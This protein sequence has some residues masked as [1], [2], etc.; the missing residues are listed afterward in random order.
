MGGAPTAW[1][2]EGRIRK[3]HQHLHH[4]FSTMVYKLCAFVPHPRRL[5]KGLTGKDGGAHLRVGAGPVSLR[6]LRMGRALRG[7][8][9]RGRV[10][11]CHHS[12]DRV[13]RCP[14]CTSGLDL[15][16]HTQAHHVFPSS[17]YPPH[18][19]TDQAGS[20]HLHCFP[21]AKQILKSKAF[22]LF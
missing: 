12:P 19:T 21:K 1:F 6:A 7:A 13:P 16:R 14:L 8:A 9:R 20:E 17:E 4:I 5:L 10:P 22:I 15:S 11:A 3:E 18:L 2:W